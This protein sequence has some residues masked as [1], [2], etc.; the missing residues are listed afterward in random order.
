[1]EPLKKLNAGLLEFV[2]HLADIVHLEGQVIDL[3]FV[4]FATSDECDALMECGEWTA[5]RTA[6]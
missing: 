1:V 5:I 4:P 3:P 2:T 6:P